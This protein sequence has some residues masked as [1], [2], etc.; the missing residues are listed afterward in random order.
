MDFTGPR[1]CALGLGADA[2]PTLKNGST[3]G[4]ASPPAILLPWGDVI[5][6]D[7]R[8]AERLQ[9]FAEDWTYLPKS[10]ARTSTVVA[11]GKC[12]DRSRGA[13]AWSKSCPEPGCYELGG[14]L[15]LPGVGPMAQSCALRRFLGHAVP[16]SSCLS[17][18]EMRPPLADFLRHEGKPLP[19]AQPEVSFP[20]GARQ[21]RF[22]DGFQDR[23]RQHLLS[24]DPRPIDRRSSPSPLNDGT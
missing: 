1:V 12:G 17:V 9:G 19:A 6:P 3:V 24:M 23:L 22:A 15:Q 18:L 4:I 5:T 21:I 16:G 7:I 20:N 13:M 8:D 10:V 11:D 2:I 14:D